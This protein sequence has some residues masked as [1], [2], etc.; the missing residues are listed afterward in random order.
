MNFLDIPRTIHT[1]EQAEIGVVKSKKA[2]DFFVDLLYDGVQNI[3]V[4]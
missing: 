2:V 3:A 4:L 1:L